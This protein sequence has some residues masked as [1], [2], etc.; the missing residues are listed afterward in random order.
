MA[1]VLSGI[2]ASLI[3]QRADAIDTLARQIAQTIDWCRG[4]DTLYEKGCR[5]FL[6][7]GP[8]SALAR[9]VRARFTDVEARAVDDFRSL[10]AAGDWTISKLVRRRG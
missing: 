1:P 10:P 4:L 9:M 6:E 8:G 2:D 5:V 3:T 7:L